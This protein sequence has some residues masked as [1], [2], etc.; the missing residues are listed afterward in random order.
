MGFS[1]LVTIAGRFRENSG[2]EELLRHIGAISKLAGTRYW[3]TTHQRWQTFILDAY[4]L[5]GAQGVRRGDFAPEEMKQGS[6]LYFEQVDNLS[7]KGIYRMHI[8]E[9][10]ANRVV[11]DVENVSVMRY[12][13]MPVLH[14]GDAQSV[15]FLDREPENGWRCYEMVRTG[16]GANRLISGNESSAINR[17]VALYRELVGVPTDQE[18]PAAR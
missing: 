8:A 4:A 6:V 14:P 9:V 5:T 1:T 3:S 18:P 7:G 16:K 10:S 15:Y 17:A 2:E 12:L 11:F 13:L